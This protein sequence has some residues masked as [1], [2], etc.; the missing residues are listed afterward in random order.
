MVE[1]CLFLWSFN[2]PQLVKT[3]RLKAPFAAQNN[4]RQLIGFG[5]RC[6]AP[7]C[8]CAVYARIA[9]LAYHMP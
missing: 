1:K 2:K 4:K 7:L 9:P 5:T 3:V 6:R 8:T